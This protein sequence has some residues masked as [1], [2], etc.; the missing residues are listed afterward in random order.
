MRISVLWRLAEVPRLYYFV[1]CTCA[2]FPATLV[3]RSRPGYSESGVW[4]FLM[5]W[6]PLGCCVPLLDAIILP[7]RSKLARGGSLIMMSFEVRACKHA[8]MHICLK[9]G[10]CLYVQGFHYAFFRLN[11]LEFYNKYEVPS[12]ATPPC[13]DTDMCMP[14]R[15]P[16]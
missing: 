4:V 10:M 1:F 16:S 11:Q 15:F 13:A 8:R 14:F 12:R 3:V 2:L 9:D 7:V 6:V 5:M